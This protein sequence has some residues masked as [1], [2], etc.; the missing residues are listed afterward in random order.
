MHVTKNWCW[1]F[2]ATARFQDPDIFQKAMK[3]C[4]DAFWVWYFTFLDSD[5]NLVPPRLMLCHDV[6]IGIVDVFLCSCS[7]IRSCYY[8]QAVMYRFEKWFCF[9]AAVQGTDHVTIAVQWRTDLKNGCVCSCS[10]VRSFY[11]SHAVMFRCEKWMY[12]QLFRRQAVLLK[13]CQDV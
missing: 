6:Q 11:Y 10:G 7:G 2:Q 1:T 12:V 3:W 8:S 4:W 5:F 13:L 9:C